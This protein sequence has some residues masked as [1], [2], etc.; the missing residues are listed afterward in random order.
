MSPRWDS[1]RPP[2]RFSASRRPLAW[3]LA[4]LGPALVT[5]GV[6]TSFGPVAVLPSVLF[7]AVVVGAALLG[8]LR[9]GVVASVLSSV[10]IWYAV[11]PPGNTFTVDGPGQATDEVLALALFVVI[12]IAAAAFFERLEHALDQAHVAR[13]RVAFLAEASEVLASSLELDTTFRRLA[14]LGVDA[15]AEWGTVDLLDEETGEIRRVAVAHRDRAREQELDRLAE[16]RPFLALRADLVD[17]VVAGEVVAGV[18]DDAFVPETARD[19]AGVTILRG[20]APRSYLLV[21]LV[22]GGAV[23]GAMTFVRGSS[24]PRFALTDVELARELARRAEI[25]VDNARLYEREREANERLVLLGEASR[26]LASTLDV[27]QA[28]R[29]MAAVLVPDMADVCYLDLLEEDRVSR[30]ASVADGHPEAELL[31]RWPP[32]LSGA[33]PISSVL[34]TGETVVIA[35]IGEDLLRR[36]AREPAH[37]ELAV[38][39]GFRSC[40]AG[41]LVTRGQVVG[42]LTVFRT[43]EGRAFRRADVGVVEVLA[44][45]VAMAVENARLFDRQRELAETLQRSLLP[46]ALPEHPGIAAAARYLPAGAAMD[47]GGDW[48][49]V[50]AVRGGTLAVALGDVAGHGAHAASVMGQ[51]RNALRAYLVEDGDPARALARLDALLTSLEPGEMATVTCAVIDTEHATLDVS[52]AGHLPPLLVDARGGA[53]RVDHH[54]GLPLGTGAAAEYRTTRFHMEPGELLLLYTDGLVEDRRRALDVSLEHLLGVVTELSTQALS[55]ARFCDAL[56]ACLLGNESPDDDVAVLAVQLCALGPELVVRVPADPAVMA[57][58]RRTLRRWLRSVAGVGD[59][60][61]PRIVAAV[62]EACAN[63][64]EHGGRAPSDRFTLIARTDGDAVEICVR[65]SGRWRPARGTNGGH[66]LVL[67]RALADGVDL[68]TGGDG[69]E[70]VLRWER[71]PVPR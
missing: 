32:E 39:V 67:M 46:R 25:A 51:L 65:D 45:R 42:A 57:P 35:D 33:D 48:Y 22:Q 18:V 43:G 2:G 30:Y 36:A 64:V 17:R 66:G 60:A 62:G 29:R 12:A 5:L 49:D 26:V 14:R 53:R 68:V 1:L 31:E 15:L 9:P 59:A 19:D 50:F 54:R 3:A 52:S 38:R 6:V 13:S 56:V 7:A 70:I 16:Y 10:G 55:P 27:E 71:E 40:I 61:M 44:R 24:Q 34:R 8:G 4:I 28:F 21:P 58:L 47:V 63:A 11:L 41:P 23:V 20:L 69:T 37:F